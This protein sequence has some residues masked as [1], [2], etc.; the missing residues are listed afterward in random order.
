MPWRH[1]VL[2]ILLLV[3]LGNDAPCGASQR[4]SNAGPQHT[5]AAN[6]NT[7]QRA[8]NVDQGAEESGPFSGGGR[9]STRAE[10][11]G[12][13]RRDRWSIGV[14]TFLPAQASLGTS[15]PAGTDGADFGCASSPVTGCTPVVPRFGQ[16]F[17]AYGRTNR[18]IPGL[19]VDAGMMITSRIDVGLGIDVSTYA[20]SVH[21]STTP[22]YFPGMPELLEA[23]ASDERWLQ[24][25]LAGRLKYMSKEQNTGGSR[26][27]T[28]YFGLGGGLS[29]FAFLPVAGGHG[30]FLAPG[31]SSPSGRNL[32]IYGWT[33]NLQLSTGAQ[34]KLGGTPLLDIEAR[35]V[36]LATNMV[37]ASGFRVGAG[38]RYKF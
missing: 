3:A 8:D 15:V 1:V 20:R 13:T 10:A 24:I 18:A 36:W 5:L 32:L 23:R 21:P 28:P 14:R 26:R 37:D 19:S 6:E 11:T 17:P 35:Y 9:T 31:R 22:D 2:P 4:E 30:E 16:E 12:H 33:P 34:F 7:S 38:L 29:R 25:D 27:V